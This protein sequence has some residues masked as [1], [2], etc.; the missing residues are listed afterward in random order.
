M[1]GWDW[2]GYGGYG[3]GDYDFYDSNN[4]DFRQ[5]YPAYAPDRIRPRDLGLGLNING[6][7]PYSRTYGDAY[8]TVFDY[9]GNWN[10]PFGKRKCS[11][12]SKDHMGRRL[13]DVLQGAGAI[14][15]PN[16]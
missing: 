7:D 4:P 2:G 5:A 6:I 9:G 12:A 13:I 10:P 8:S 11:E 3:V 16:A 14:A 1:S 15:S